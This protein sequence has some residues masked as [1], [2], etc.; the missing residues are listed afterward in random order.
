MSYES[1]IELLVTDIQHQIV[2]QQDE[3]IYQAV[4]SFIPNINREEL[5]KAL[6]YDRDQYNRGY[7]DGR[8]DAQDELVRC[9]VCKHL[10]L[11]AEGEHDPDDCVCDYWMTDGLTDSDFCSRGERRTDEQ[12]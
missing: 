3:Q 6:A 5:L 10:V 12:R 11:T 8:Q 2:Q 4:M 9:K 1:P 7:D